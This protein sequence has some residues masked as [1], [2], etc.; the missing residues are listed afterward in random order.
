[1]LRASLVFALGVS[2]GYARVPLWSQ[3]NRVLVC[4][5]QEPLG[6]LCSRSVS[7]LLGC[8]GTTQTLSV[9]RSHSLRVREAVWYLWS[10]VTGLCSLLP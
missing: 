8:A 2:D 5:G 10:C 7:S 1:M 3:R 6:H 9:H 4:V